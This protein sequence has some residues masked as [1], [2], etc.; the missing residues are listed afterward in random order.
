M[1]SPNLR[2]IRLIFFGLAGG[3]VL[4]A[5]APIADNLLRFDG[6]LLRAQDWSNREFKDLVSTFAYMTGFALIFVIC[7]LV[8]KDAGVTRLSMVAFINAV[9]VV[10]ACLDAKSLILGFPLLLSFIGLTVEI[11]RAIKQPKRKLA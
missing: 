6:A 3:F 5:I 7:A 11:V 10:G 8:L 2:T 9:L 1:E 4:I